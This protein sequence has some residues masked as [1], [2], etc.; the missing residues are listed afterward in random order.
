MDNPSE[1]E[2][3][4]SIEQEGQGQSCDGAPC[5]A[6]DFPTGAFG[7]LRRAILASKRPEQ[8]SEVGVHG[9]F[10]ALLEEYARHVCA[11]CQADLG[12][13]E[14]PQRDALC[15]QAMV[16]AVENLQGAHDVAAV[17]RSRLSSHWGLLKLIGDRRLEELR[18][19]RRDKR[20]R[21]TPRAVG[22]CLPARFTQP[23]SAA[24]SCEPASVAT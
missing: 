21:G 15:D 3:G 9:P 1:P 11:A 8:W 5:L 2:R 16:A 14:R 19:T 23:R 4:C 10:D 13:F 24:K 7:P 18:R 20:R 17:M 12:D 6:R 22:E